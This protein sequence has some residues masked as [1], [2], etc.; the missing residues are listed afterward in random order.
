MSQ[1]EIVRSNPPPKFPRD[2]PDFSLVLGGPLYQLY[3]RTRLARPP[4]KLL[5]RRM[6][7]IP[8]ICW[9]PLW[10][11]AAAAG[12]LSSGVP[13]PFF[14]DPEVHIKLLVALPILIA[15]EVLAHARI[16]NVVAQFRE[17]NIVSQEDLPHFEKMVASAMRL[18]NSVVMELG[19]FAAVVAIGYWM[20]GQNV[21]LTV[22][23]LSISSWYAIND[24]FRM[25]PTAAGEYYAFVSLTIFRFILLRWYFRL[26]IWYRFL[27]EV[28]GLPLH[29]NLYHPDRAGGL[30]FLSES[31]IAFAPV[32]VAQTT[33]LAAVFYARILYA[34]TRLQDWTMEIA[35]AVLLF[36]LLL[37]L[38]LGFFAVQLDRAARKARIEFGSLGSHYVDEFRDKWILGRGRAG[39]ALLGTSD[40]QSL[41]DLANSY[42]VVSGI[43]LLPVS[44]QAFIRLVVVIVLPLLPL[45]LTVFPLSEIIKRVFK[46]VL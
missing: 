14:R 41:A 19:L 44:K 39:E 20:W 32:F 12:H 18:R 8:L 10:P 40:I 45:M 34:G 13:V 24:G 21:K 36:V 15:V 43:S 17:R 35:C 38:P 27:W 7:V 2:E 26:L 33:S 16:Q 23:S 42:Q 1:P 4:L 37:I 29:F 46:M 6:V 28:R 25:H 9:L 5:H 11:L 30:G 22:S 3:L 31:L